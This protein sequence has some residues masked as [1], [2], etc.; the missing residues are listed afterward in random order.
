[1]GRGCYL[2]AA[3]RQRR[4]ILL[5]E[6]LSNMY[7]SNKLQNL[8]VL[9]AATSCQNGAET[10][11]PHRGAPR[12]STR[13]ALESAPCHVESLEIRKQFCISIKSRNNVQHLCILGG[14]GGTA[15]CIFGSTPW[16]AI[17]PFRCA[18]LQSHGRRDSALERDL[19]FASSLS[20]PSLQ[21][22]LPWG[23]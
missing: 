1:M 13:T 18:N 22:C 17:R 7:C 9:Q 20:P 19:F 6:Q 15:F 10:L 16:V 11:L 3:R 14:V 21:S 12:H 2:P 8:P 23:T 4:L 5:R